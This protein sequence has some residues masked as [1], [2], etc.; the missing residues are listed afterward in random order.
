MQGFLLIGAVMA[1]MTMLALGL[2][3]RAAERAG[4]AAV[5]T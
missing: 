4:T 5:S 3:N 2:K 1:L